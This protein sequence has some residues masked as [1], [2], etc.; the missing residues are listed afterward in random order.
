MQT[1]TFKNLFL[2]ALLFMGINI[3][4]ANTSH[5]SDKTELFNSIETFQTHSEISEQLDVVLVR[6]ENEGADQGVQKWMSFLDTLQDVSKLEQIKAVNTFA[7][8]KKYRTDEKNY[9]TGD[10]WATPKEFLG[11]GGD[12]EDFA[13]IKLLSLRYL[14][15]STDE[16]RMVILLDTELRTPHAVLAVYVDGDVL[17]LDNQRSEVVSHTTLSNYV[18]LYSINS[19]G[20][21]MHS[22][23]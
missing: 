13:I 7:N 3:M 17:I 10:Y 6:Y 11:R 21:W 18:P 9:G 19:V 16:L 12:C 5:A 8:N 1:K 20:W 2:I 23:S 14:G 22:F 15:F 4:T